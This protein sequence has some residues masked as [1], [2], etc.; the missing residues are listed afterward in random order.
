LELSELNAFYLK[1][2]LWIPP[3][4]NLNIYRLILV[5]A[6]NYAAIHQIYTYINDKNVKRI[7][8][9]AALSLITCA[10]ELLLIFKLSP[11]EFPN[12]MDPERKKKFMIGVPIYLF[13][14]VLFMLKI[15]RNPNEPGERGEGDSGSPPGS[16]ALHSHRE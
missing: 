10:T 5:F 13:L 7:G 15:Y 2:L 4:N 12:S 8:A 14:C 1:F 16:P 6:L 11:G 3:E 9:Y